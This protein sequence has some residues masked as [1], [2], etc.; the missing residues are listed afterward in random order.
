[1][2]FL[3]IF[4]SLLSMGQSE[5]K[6]EPKVTEATFFVKG[7]AITEQFSV[8]LNQGKNIL[9]IESL[10]E[11]LD[12]GSLQVKSSLPV[13]IIS[14]VFGVNYRKQASKTPEILSLEQ[15]KAT[16][17]AEIDLMLDKRKALDAKWEILKANREIEVV[18]A[19]VEELRSLM[20][21]QEQQ[22]LMVLAEQRKVDA[23]IEKLEEDRGKIIIQIEDLE[24]NLA[25][26]KGQI[27]LVLEAEREGIAEMEINYLT[28]KASWNPQYD[29]KAS[30]LN[31]PLS[32][33][34]F[35]NYHQFTGKPWKEV[36]VSFST[37]DPF[38]YTSAPELRPWNLDFMESRELNAPSAFML[39]NQD[40]DRQLSG[41]VIDGQGNP[42]YPAT[43]QIPGTSIGTQTD[44]RGRFF[45]MIPTETPFVRVSLMGYRPRDYSLKRN[46]KT[47]R[48]VLSESTVALNESI[49]KRYSSSW[50]ESE[51]NEEFY[52]I[53]Q[54]S[55]PE[56]R[57]EEKQTNFTITVAEALDVPSTTEKDRIELIREEVD[58]SYQ[59]LLVPKESPEAHLTAKVPNLGNL[60]IPE[61]AAKLYFEESYVG[62]TYLDQNSL[63]DTLQL[64]LGTDEQVIIQRDRT[65]KDS[66]TQF[67]GGNTIESREYT[68]SV[69]NNKSKAIPFLLQDQIPVSNNEE[70]V[71]STQELSNGTLN[72]DTGI[73]RWEGSLEAK[74]LEVW[75]IRFEV[76]YPSKRKVIIE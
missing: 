11:D 37:Q 51:I 63:S 23:T 76:R 35:A 67:L 22:T 54:I 7:A 60:G 40:R 43:L 68:L 56:T 29:L 33:S 49:P 73:I 48:V 16:L 27:N 15:K 59:Y 2:T 1:M 25:N 47:I 45:L 50:V 46:E 65:K 53:T 32:L 74:T 71:V 6:V 28:K 3:L 61:G 13:S 5:K 39:Q 9:L 57:L 55:P 21:F 64:S 17:E 30:D 42:L 24:K 41:V 66:R 69:R 14:S 34:L 12:I 44:E 72:T 18:S 4:S 70:I 31:S 36:S 10:P 8:P 38:L 26:A 19:R 20:E 62:I 58:A 52:E 75:K